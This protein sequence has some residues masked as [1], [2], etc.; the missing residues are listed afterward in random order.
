MTA[1]PRTALL[2][3]IAGLIPFAWSA[4]TELSPAA[5]TWTLGAFGPRF[6]GPYMGLSY[7]TIILA[8]M[9]GVLWGFATRATGTQAAIGYGLSVVPAL[10][11]F[12]LVGDGPTSSA[13]WLSAGFL[14]LL[15][16]DAVFSGQGLAPPWWMPLRLLLTV[17]VLACLS[18][19]II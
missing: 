11:A 7:G 18:V 1:I 10:W 8:F 9:S 14:L 5:F 19:T 6:V 16:L 2:L 12:F 15:G 13:I 3:G 4:I 17:G